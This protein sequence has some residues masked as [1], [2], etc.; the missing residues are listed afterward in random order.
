MRS[1][2]V[3]QLA[4]NWVEDSAAEITRIGVDKKIDSFGEGDLEYVTDILSTLWEIVNKDGDIE[5]PSPIIEPPPSIPAP[6]KTRSNTPRKV[7][8]SITRAV[9]RS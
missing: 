7:P 2:Y 8:S 4:F 6:T 3:N 5:A 9:S 1:L